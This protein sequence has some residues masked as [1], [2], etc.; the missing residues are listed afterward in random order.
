MDGL[1]E[2][3]RDYAQIFTALHL[4]GVAFGLGGATVS[5][6]LFFKFIRDGK[7]DK[8]EKEALLVVSKIIWVGVALLFVSGVA[9]LIPR[10]DYLLHNSRFILKMVVVGVVV[11]NGIIL[12]KFFAPHLDSLTFKGDILSSKS[13]KLFRKMAVFGT[14]SFISWYSAFILGNVSFIRSSALYLVASY[15]VVLA[16]SIVVGQILIKKIFPLILKA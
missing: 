4:L 8:N 14:I 15:F 7:V 2:F 16:V 9:M 12:N 3:F 1:V 10:S 6:I 13:F 5:D 11:T